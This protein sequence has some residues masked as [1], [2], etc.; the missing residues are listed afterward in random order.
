MSMAMALLVDWTATMRCK[1]WAAGLAIIWGIRS[2]ARTLPRG[3][4]EVA[5]KDPA[6]QAVSSGD[7]HR[8][9]RHP[10]DD[11]RPEEKT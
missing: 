1:D 9:Q 5:R 8:F 10:G 3:D 11:T 4:R 6:G 2:S 7:C